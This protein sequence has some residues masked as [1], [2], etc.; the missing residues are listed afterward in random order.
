MEDRYR[1][2]FLRDSPNANE[3]Q[4]AIIEKIYQA[5]VDAKNVISGEQTHFTPT[6]NRHLF[7][8]G[9]GGAGKTW[10]FNVIFLFL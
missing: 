7:V 4:K 3:E 1:E 9:E 5:V 2:I 10:T 6:V 8:T